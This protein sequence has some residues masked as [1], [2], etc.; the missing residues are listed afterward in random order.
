MMRRVATLRDMT[1]DLYLNATRIN[2][3]ACEMA[4]ILS[5]NYLN[6]FRFEPFFTDIYT[7]CSCIDES[8]KDKKVEASVSDYRNR[9]CID[10]RNR[11]CMDYRNRFCMDYRNR[12]CMDYRNRFCIDYRNRFCIDYRNRFC[13]DY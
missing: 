8:Q 1:C 3:T 10:Y 4:E 9:F 13:M 12:F 5:K 11:F 2:S 6:P 7:L